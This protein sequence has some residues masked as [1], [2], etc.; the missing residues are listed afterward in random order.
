MILPEYKI[1]DVP[2]VDSPVPDDHVF[3]DGIDKL[4]AADGFFSIGVPVTPS[5]V[6]TI[7]WVPQ[8]AIRHAR[9]LQK[10]NDFSEFPT[11][12]LEPDYCRTKDG[13]RWPRPHPKHIENARYAKGLLNLPDLAKKDQDQPKLRVDL[14]LLKKT[15]DFLTQWVD[16]QARY[17]IVTEHDKDDDLGEYET[18]KIEESRPAKMACE[19]WMRDDEGYP[20][21]FTPKKEQELIALIM[22]MA[23]RA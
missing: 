22:P 9:L 12:E 18:S 3:F 8:S 16:L 13:T 19:V 2:I 7:G 5:P 1:E 4:W 17:A 21:L 10:R 14:L 20:L 15:V 11:I 6:D 23:T